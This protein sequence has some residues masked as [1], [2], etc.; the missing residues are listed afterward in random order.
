M[1]Q[2]PDV[3]YSPEVITSCVW[4]AIKG[5][6]G[7]ADLHRTP[8]QSIGERV[9]LEQSGPVRLAT[10]EGRI[11]LDVYITVR[12]GARVPSLVA[13]LRTEVGAY[14]ERM[15]GIRPDTINV[16]VDDIVWDDPPAQ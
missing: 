4:D 10:S 7:I 12:P 3:S 8:L 14:L 6:P 9:H 5:L 2:Q 13:A 16:H 15:T 11:V 1:S